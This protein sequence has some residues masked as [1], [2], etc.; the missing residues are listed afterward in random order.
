MTKPIYLT[1]QEIRGLTGKI[2]YKAQLRALK[3]MGIDA[4]ERPDGSL[5]VSRLAYERA[6]GGLPAVHQQRDE[7]PDFDAL[8]S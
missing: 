8:V 3:G 2:R 1:E 4:K 5:A 7:E 6:M